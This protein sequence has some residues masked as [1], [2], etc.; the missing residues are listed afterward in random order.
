MICALCRQEQALRSSHIIPK[1]V[2]HWLKESSG[3]GFL[4]FSQNPNQ[5][6]QD[7]LKKEL[8]CGDC[9][10]LLSKFESEFADNIFYPLHQNEALRLSKGPWFSYKSWCMKFAV[11]VSWRCLMLAREL[12]LSHFSED[13]RS[14]VDEALETWRAFL[15]GE[16]EHPGAFE[17]HLVLCDHLA[18]HTCH[19][20]PSNFNRYL[21]R[22]VEL[23]PIRTDGHAFIFVKMCRVMIF[24]FI[25]ETEKKVWNGT[26]LRVRSGQIGGTDY[27]LPSPLLGYF[28]QRAS[29]LAA[30]EGS[31]SARQQERILKDSE[32]KLDR[33]LG[34]ETLQA[35]LYDHEMFGRGE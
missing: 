26:K 2:Y 16:A 11:S 27:T 8:L 17:Q 3:T 30:I 33:V 29:K 15:L 24:G 31:L 1:F 6:V 28:K 9:E 22:S 32:Q 23:Q 19:D 14:L 10:L 5:R 4:R 20:L 21:L 35:Q 7:G 34:S 12:G 13:Q 25:Q 18:E